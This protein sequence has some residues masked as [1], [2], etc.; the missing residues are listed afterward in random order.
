MAQSPTTE[1]LT[2]ERFTVSRVLPDRVRVMVVEGPDLGREAFLDGERLAIGTDA[3]NGLVLTDSSVS[4]R[5][6]E[7]VR[8]G[9]GV[10]LRDLGSTNGTFLAAQRVREAFVGPGAHVRV[11]RTELVL[12]P[13]E[14][15]MLALTSTEPVFGELVGSSLAMRRLFGVL[16]RMAQTEIALL[17]SGE[18]GTGKELA[19]RALHAQSRRSAAPFL[20]LDCGALDRELAGSDLFG[21]EPGAFTGATGR[22]A[23]IFEQARGGT[24]FLDEIG[25]LPLELQPKLLRVLEQ[26]E[27]RRLGSST[28]VPVDF[29]LV[30]ATHRDLKEMAAKGTF[31]EDL[32]YRV[33]QVQVRLPPLRE[34]LEDLPLLCERLLGRAREAGSAPPQLRGLS[35][36][37]VTVLGSLAWKGNV[38]ELRNVLERA[39]ALCTGP[40]MT[41][42]DLML[43]ADERTFDRATSGLQ[44]RTLDD[45]EREAIQAT[46]AL[47]EGNKTRAAKLLGIVPNTLRERMRRHGLPW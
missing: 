43:M 29:R 21:H 30:A 8:T 26:R 28:Y 38:R 46:L 9:G 23:G 19:A 31:R 17:I 32:Y 37:A 12:A 4:R 24:V 22:R 10:T 14:D 3:S 15:A 11:G 2:D 36:E 44:G 41:P 42:A 18:T 27:V 45:I 6:A 5:H 40:S 33:A 25:E 1:P 13:C 34:R 20:P 39:A 35:S 47:C 7:L 16:A